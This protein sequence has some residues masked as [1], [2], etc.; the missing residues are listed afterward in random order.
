[1]QIGGN[2]V[3]MKIILGL[4][5][6]FATSPRQSHAQDD[7]LAGSFLSGTI[8]EPKQ[9]LFTVIEWTTPSVRHNMCL[10]NG[11]FWN[12]ICANRRSPSLSLSRTLA[13]DS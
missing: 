10:S 13:G 11:I 8:P 3:E 7:S 12:L 9:A 6:L 5:V 2:Q 1:M 4:A